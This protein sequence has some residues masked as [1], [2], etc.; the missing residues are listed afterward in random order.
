MDTTNPTASD[1]KTILW[2]AGGCLAVLVC[3]AAAVFLGFGG[4]VWMSTQTADEAT[5]ILDVP[6]TARVGEPYT[7]RITVTNTSSK[8]IELYGV[9]LSMNYLA[10]IA[11]V[12]TDPAYTE[13]NQFDALGGGETYFTYYF[14]QAIAPGESL[15]VSFAGTAVT[16][17]DFSGAV[18]VCIDSDYNCIN[19]SARTVIR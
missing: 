5:A 12:S 14:H 8:E 16:A 19:N 4:L 10:G 11:I 1:R 2:V 17:G 18:D 6:A 15:T 13:T 7:F 9:D 3:I